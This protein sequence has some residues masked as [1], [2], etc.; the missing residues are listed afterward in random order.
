M[1]ETGIPVGR[2]TVIFTPWTNIASENWWL[3][4]DFFPFWEGL[5]AGAILVSGRVNCFKPAK[6]SKRPQTPG[7]QNH[8]SGRSDL[9]QLATS[10]THHPPRQV[11]LQKL[12][13]DIWVFPKIGV[14]QIIHFNR[15]FHYKPSILG[16]PYFWKHPHRKMNHTVDGS[17]IR[18]SPVEVGSLSHCLQGLYKSQVVQDFLPST[19]G[20]MHVHFN[21]LHLYIWLGCINHLVRIKSQCWCH[22]KDPTPTCW[23]MPPLLW[24]Q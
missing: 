19:V 11:W 2:N 9:G 7:P 17:E 22:L 21:Y 12:Q 8:P 13:Q 23:M 3:Q 14:P 15:V 20:W 24:S 18:R 10:L 4:D 6:N 5:L 1:L 16:Y